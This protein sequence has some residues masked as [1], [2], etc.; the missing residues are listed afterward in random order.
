MSEG[1]LV[2]ISAPSGSG[3]TTIIQH[4][5]EKHFNLHFSVSATNRPAREHETDGKDY[6]FIA[7]ETFHSKINKDEF[8]EW[9]EVY[10]GRFYGS[11]IAHVNQML[12]EGKNVIFDV[13]VV[14]GL[15]IKKYYQEQALS[16]FVKLPSLETLE[17]RLRQ[18][19]TDNETDI[20]NRLEKA[21]WEMNFAKKFDAILINDSLQKCHKDAEKLVSDFLHKH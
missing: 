20:M 5:M 4:L 3:K 11:L 7:T 15:N 21:A 16:I 9:E 10:E 13:D 14:G 2:I 19:G 18:R 17:M 6:L 12:S 1:K 8:L